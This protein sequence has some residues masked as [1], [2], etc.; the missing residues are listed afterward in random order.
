MRE[1]HLI[2]RD[3]EFLWEARLQGMAPEID[4]KLY[5]TDIEPQPDRAPARAGNI[6]TVEITR[7]IDYDLVGRVVALQETLTRPVTSLPMHPAREISTAQ[8]H[9]VGA[10]WI[11][12][13]DADLHMVSQGMQYLFPDPNNIWNTLYRLGNPDLVKFAEGLGV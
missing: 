2:S 8:A 3:A 4:G 9:N 12:L 6:A 10:I 5:L 7:S 13:D 11:V 1:P